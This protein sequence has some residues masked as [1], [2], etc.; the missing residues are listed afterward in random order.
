MSNLG[1]LFEIFTRMPVDEVRLDVGSEPYVIAGGEMR[2]IGTQPMNARQITA[3]AAEVLPI[4]ELREL[5]GQR[6]RVVRHEH[7]GETYVI[8]IVREV[9][10]LSL[11]IRRPRAEMPMQE[12][13]GAGIVRNH[14]PAPANVVTV[15]PRLAPVLEPPAPEPI[16]RVSSK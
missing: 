10:G 16:R 9:E 6:P 3:V 7:N 14:V 15:S 4:E 1:R 5:S 8:E 12:A 13:V 11:A 2:H